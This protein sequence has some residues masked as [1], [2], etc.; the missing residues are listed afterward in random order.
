MY[1]EHSA[2]GVVV[3]RLKGVWQFVAVQP[4]H[5]NDVWAL[6]K[7]HLDPGET[8]QQAALREVREETGLRVSADVLLDDINYSFRK[9][10][11]QETIRKKV[12]F[13]LL[14]WES[15]SL[16]PQEEEIQDVRWV[17]LEAADDELTYPGERQI[18]LRAATI[19]AER[20][21]TA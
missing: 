6:P 3:R 20:A 7:G 17:D 18:A 19:L 13:F 2:G 16:I 15:G 1:D 8:E 4:R 10:G 14:R 12:T 21:R 11:T 9:S 5:R